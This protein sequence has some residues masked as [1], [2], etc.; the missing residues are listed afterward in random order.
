MAAQDVLS[1]FNTIAKTVDH[2]DAA[3]GSGYANDYGDDAGPQSEASPCSPLP[4]SLPSFSVPSRASAKNNS[5][6]NT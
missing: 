1:T 2:H 6:N 3:G 5:S 4:P